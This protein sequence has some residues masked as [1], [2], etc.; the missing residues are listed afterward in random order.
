MDVKNTIVANKPENGIVGISTLPVPCP[1]ELMAEADDQWNEE[2]FHMLTQQIGIGADYV[3]SREEVEAEI[4]E[5]EK[6]LLTIEEGESFK[7]MKK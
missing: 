7:E 3:W 5:R 1:W 4:V 2:T 6:I